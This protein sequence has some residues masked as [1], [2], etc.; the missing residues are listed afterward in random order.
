MID[1]GELLVVEASP[2]GFKQLARAGVLSGK[3][4]TVPVVANGGAYCRSHGGDLV[5]V[6]L[7]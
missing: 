6:D 4:W 5:A 1:G 2:A 3:C 7:R